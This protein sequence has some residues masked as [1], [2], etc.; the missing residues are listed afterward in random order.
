MPF[1]C[2]WGGE[3]EHGC[4]SIQVEVSKQLAGVSFLLHIVD[5]KIKC[6]LSALE[7]SAITY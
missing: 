4:H 2:M 1:H 5:P 3:G 6:R 7:A